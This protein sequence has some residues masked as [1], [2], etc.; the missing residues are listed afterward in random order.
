MATKVKPSRLQITGTP[1]AWNVPVYV[2]QDTFQRWVWWG[3]WASFWRFLSLWNSATWMP[4][5]FPEATPYTYITWDYFIVEVVSSATPPVNY[6]PDWSSYTGVASSVTES[7]EV[8]VWD[9][10][11]YDGQ[12]WLLQSNHWKTVSFSNIAW[13]ALDNASID[14]YLNTKTFYISSTSDLVN[15]QAAYDWYLAGK[16]PIIVY[17]QAWYDYWYY[18]LEKVYSSSIRFRCDTSTVY[19]NYNNNSTLWYAN[20][21]I[22][23]SNWVVTGINSNSYNADFLSTNKANNTS[24]VPTQDYHPAT[25]KYVDDEVA[26]KQ[27]E[28]VSGTNIRTINWTSIL[29]SWDITTPTWDSVILPLPS[30]WDDERELYAV[31]YSGKSVTFNSWSSYYQVWKFIDNTSSN[32]K[33]TVYA[34][35]WCDGITDDAT[36]G[37]VITWE[38]QNWILSVTQYTRDYFTA[39]NKWVKVFSYDAPLWTYWNI[40]SALNWQDQWW[41]VIFKRNNYLS[42]DQND[43]I[44][45]VSYWDIANNTLYL[46]SET[47]TG[48]VKNVVTYNASWQVTN[49]TTTSLSGWIQ[50]SPNSTITGIKYVWYGTESDYANLSQYYTDQ[51][52]DTEF[53]TF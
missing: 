6:R 1:Q 2:D 20:L 28:L 12:T 10:Y 35:N 44:Y 15:A 52:G 50:V 51:P 45:Y 46:L 30:V 3:W 33:F 39:L 21:S 5:S 40:S 23:Y 17:G 8:E 32:Q 49:V 34:S 4:I 53:H 26:T 7:D 14:L 27:D 13:D 22:Q 42:P 41:Q 19:N 43:T 9:T 48:L 37:Y 31:L 29:W 16:E 18:Y 47:W 11:V 25:K 24:R 36:I 38:L